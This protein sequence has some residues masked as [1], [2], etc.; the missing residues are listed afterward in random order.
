MTA[1]KSALML[2]RQCPG[3]RFFRK[4]KPVHFERLHFGGEL[5]VL[6]QGLGNL[7]L[8]CAVIKGRIRELRVKGLKFSERAFISRSTFSSSFFRG[9]RSSAMRAR[10]CAAN[11]R[12][13]LLLTG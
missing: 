1:F 13:S 8:I 6:A 10:S 7:A 4:F 3:L 9:L 12:A 5:S 2:M 11:R